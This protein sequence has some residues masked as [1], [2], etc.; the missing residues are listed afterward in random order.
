MSNSTSQPQATPTRN[1]TLEKS[2][3]WI[4]FGVLTLAIITMLSLWN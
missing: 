1:Q 2:A 3:W 4:T